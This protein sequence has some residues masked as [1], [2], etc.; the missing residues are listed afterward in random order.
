MLTFNLKKEWFAVDKKIAPDIFLNC[1][2]KLLEFLK[3]GNSI[4][5]PYTKIQ[6]MNGMFSEEKRPR[7]YAKFISMKIVNGKT[8]DLGINKPVYDI[9][10]ELIKE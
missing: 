10:F 4:C 5:C 7:M 6:F 9:E 8:T 2:I 3:K 1:K